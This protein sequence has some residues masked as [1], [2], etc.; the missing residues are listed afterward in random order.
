M[1]I[2]I[3]IGSV[4]FSCSKEIFVSLKNTMWYLVTKGENLDFQK[5]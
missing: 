3:V 4:R 2:A 5:K 1:S